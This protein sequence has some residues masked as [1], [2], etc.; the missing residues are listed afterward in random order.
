MKTSEKIKKYNYQYFI[1]NNRTLLNKLISIVNGKDNEFFIPLKS[2]LFIYLFLIIED[3]FS[4]NISK[5]ILFSFKFIILKNFV[6]IILFYLLVLKNINNVLIAYKNKI[7]NVIRSKEE[8]YRKLLEFLP[9]AVHI[10]N[11]G[12]I[13]FTNKAGAN[14]Y[15][16]DDE[17]DLIGKLDTDFTHPDYINMSINRRKKVLVEN[18]NAPLVESKCIKNNGEIIDVEVASSAINLNGEKVILSVLRDITDI[19][20]YKSMIEKTLKENKKLLEKAIENEKNKTEYFLNLSH[21][22]KT[23]LNVILGTAQ[24]LEIYKNKDFVKYDN[25]FLN[26]NVYIIKQ[27]C[28]RLLRL[29]NN[30]LDINKSDMKFLE[31]NLKNYNIVKVVEDITL[32]VAKF[33]KEK[34][35]SLIFDTEIEEKYMMC[36]VD[37]IERI[38]LNLLSNAIKYNKK[39]GEIYVNILDKDSHIS[40]SVKDTGVGIPK[41][42]ID[43]I[44]DRFRRLDASLSRQNEGSGLGLSIVK[45]FVEK[46]IGDIKVNS[47][48][49]KGTEFIV[50][51]PVVEGSTENR[52]SENEAFITEFI[53]RINIEFSDIYL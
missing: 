13:I 12:K 26:N 2:G 39:G 6:L 16:F 51:L 7:R 4:I 30:I 14:L 19:K 49:G 48:L 23:P 35:L 15:G 3:L 21:E 42:K 31:L 24:L 47:E 1:E 43:N 34:E 18:E 45:S 52:E 36:D 28:Y 8:S 29:I 41:D 20:K 11:N 27:N 37:K 40:I 44:F 53:E 25:T 33:I 46:H 38:V 50:N 10:K 22:F 9:Y 5:E 17:K 32:S